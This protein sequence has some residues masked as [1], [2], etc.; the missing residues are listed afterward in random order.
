VAACAGPIAVES[1]L[2]ILAARLVFAERNVLVLALATYVKTVMVKEGVRKSLEATFGRA[3][4]L[5]RHALLVSESYVG[6]GV[7]VYPSG[8]V[9]R[10]A[11]PGRGLRKSSMERET[12][13]HLSSRCKW[14]SSHHAGHPACGWYRTSVR[15][16]YCMYR[17]I[18]LKCASEAVGA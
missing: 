14:Y 1:A 11:M 7:L 16:A 8:A 5:F 17:M 6:S 13:V 15:P 3:R 9:S 4:S 10:S 18:P 12:S 2:A